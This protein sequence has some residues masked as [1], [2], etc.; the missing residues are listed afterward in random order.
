M[1]KYFMQFKSHVSNSALRQRCTKDREQGQTSENQGG[2]REDNVQILTQTTDSGP[3]LKPK[4]A[5][6]KIPTVLKG[7]WLIFPNI[8]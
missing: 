8:S 5:D 1:S 7:L 2:K 4:G 3:D 6:R